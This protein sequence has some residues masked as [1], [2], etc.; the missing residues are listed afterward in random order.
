MNKGSAMGGGNVVFDATKLLGETRPSVTEEQVRRAFP[1]GHPRFAGITFREMELHDKKNHDYAKG[2][3]PLGNFD[4]VSAILALYPNLK[5]SDPKVIAMVYAMKQV[6]AV[7]WGMSE[8]IE[9]RVEGLAERLQDVSV[10]SK[11]VI[12]ML[13][14]EK[15]IL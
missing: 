6:D 3:S 11:L 2:G 10:Y 1:N 8:Q 14:D 13:H 9:H 12:C 5:L 15:N 7:L 4:R